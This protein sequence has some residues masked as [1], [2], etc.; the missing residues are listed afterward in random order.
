MFVGEP[1]IPSKKYNPIRF[2]GFHFR[3]QGLSLWMNLLGWMW[4]VDSVFVGC[5]VHERCVHGL[6]LSGLSLPSVSDTDLL[7][8]NYISGAKSVNHLSVY[9]SVSC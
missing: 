2:S 3:L 5:A 1:Y 8:T 7:N 9:L 6:H 4:R